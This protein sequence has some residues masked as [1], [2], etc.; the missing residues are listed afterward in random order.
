MATID[1]RK[2]ADGTTAYTAQ[3]RLKDQGVI[4][5]SEAQTFTQKALTQDWLKRREA[6]LQVARATGV[7]HHGKLTVGHL[8]TSYVKQAKG[9]TEW[10]RTKTS[11]IKR[12]IE[13][14][15]AEKDARM[16]RAAN[17]TAQ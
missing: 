15:L 16:S 6:E 1:Q 3:I 9:V 8:L 7:L 5:H 4:V 17:T 10:G 14:G 2:R 12:L 11:D 13:S